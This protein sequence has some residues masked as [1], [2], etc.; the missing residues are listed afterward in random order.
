MQTLPMVVM[1]TEPSEDVRHIP[2]EQEPPPPH[3]D[4]ERCS[5]N[6]DVKSLSDYKKEGKLKWNNQQ[7]NNRQPVRQ[8]PPNQCVGASPRVKECTLGTHVP[9]AAW[10]VI[11]VEKQGTTKAYVEATRDRK[12]LPARCTLPTILPATNLVSTTTV[13][14][15][16]TKDG[17]RQQGQ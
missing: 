9:H 10:Y 2:T 6:Y 7:S 5:D 1:G 17:P 3:K 16:L 4:E 15:D 12:A 14:L 11:S 8:S 13:L